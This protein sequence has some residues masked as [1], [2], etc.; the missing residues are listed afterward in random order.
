VEDGKGGEGGR[1]NL[2]LMVGEGQMGKQEKRGKEDG[3]ACV[4]LN[5]T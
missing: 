3:L 4:S 1:R 2:L 5:C